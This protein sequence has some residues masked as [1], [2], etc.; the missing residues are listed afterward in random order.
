MLEESNELNVYNCALVSHRYNTIVKVFLKRGE[1]LHGRVTEIHGKQEIVLTE[2]GPFWNRSH[3]VR[4]H[5]IS[6][7][8]AR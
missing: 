1:V 6:I 8:A 5:D 7:I 4:L 2:D 3:L